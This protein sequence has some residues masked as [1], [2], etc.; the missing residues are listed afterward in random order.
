MQ[1]NL[2]PRATEESEHRLR[3]LE[4]LA[5]A[6]DE[7]GYAATTIADIVRHAKVSKRTF[8]EHFPDKESCFLDAYGMAS[9]LALATVRHA[10]KVEAPWREQIRAATQA[11]LL[12][13]ESQP[14]LTRT[15]LLEI[16]AA[17]PA[18]LKRRREVHD[19]FAETLRKLVERTRRTAPEVRPLSGPMALA[20]VGGIHELVL[21]ALETGRGNKLRELGETA[22]ELVIAVLSS[23]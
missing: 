2:N 5:R 18:A 10:A 21:T 17:G 8:Y 3:L 23:K 6:V 12:A 9:E 1:A 11:Y 14:A 20:L 7:K 15:F 13:L 16:H 4:G 19:R 22:V